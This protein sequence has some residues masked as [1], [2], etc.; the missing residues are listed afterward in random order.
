MVTAA[1]YARSVGAV[2]TVTLNG[3]DVYYER[4][5]ERSA[6]AVLQRVRRHA[7]VQPRC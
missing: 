2:P 6:A 3:I 5:G 4:G 1:P 7:R